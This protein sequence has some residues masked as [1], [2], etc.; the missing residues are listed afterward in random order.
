V[1]LRGIPVAPGLAVGSPVFHDS[2]DVDVP[3]LSLRP[4]DVR[5]EQRRLAAAIRRVRR[6]LEQVE[7][8]IEAEVGRRDARIFSVQALLLEDPSFRRAIRERIASQLVNAEVAV[9]DAVVAWTARLAGVGADIDRDPVSDLRDVGRRLLR[10]L[11]GQPG[12]VAAEQQHDGQRVILVTREILPS[13]TAHLDRSRLAAIVTAAGGIASHAAILARGLGIPAVTDV[14][15][16]SLPA[17]GGPWIV[18]GTEG[19]LVLNPEAADLERARRQGQKLQKARA[20]LQAQAGDQ[21]RTRDGVPIDL[22]LNVENFESVQPEMLVGLQGVGLF[23][24]EFLFMERASFPSEEEQY[25]DYVGALRL[26]GG[27]QVSGRTCSTAS[28]AR[29]CARRRTA[30][31]AS[32]CR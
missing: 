24:T 1:T 29:C 14:D 32:C 2:R 9:R 27:A 26:V 8:R 23:R 21:V 20:E 5:A 16:A 11:A 10:I 19:R 12:R 17:A 28:C 3:F 30:A 4:E 22:M 6:N 7:H 13:D 25:K 18:D 15:V 31:C